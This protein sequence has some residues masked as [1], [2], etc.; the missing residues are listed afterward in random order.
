MD[1]QVLLSLLKNNKGN[2]TYQS[3]LTRWIDRLLPRWIDKLLPFD[4]TV[5]HVPDKNMGSA[6]WFSRCPKYP[7]PPPT[8]SDTDYVINLINTFKHILQRAER[9]SANTKAI[10]T[11]KRKGIIRSR[12]QNN[13]STHNFRLNG[14]GKQSLHCLTTQNSLWKIVLKRFV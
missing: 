2:K 5:H 14:N 8:E 1:H 7:A 3:R 11:L 10:N 9:V 13:T 4:F 6:Y 12:E